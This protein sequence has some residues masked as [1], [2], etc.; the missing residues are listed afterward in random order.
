M[1][2]D[3]RLKLN[4]LIKEGNVQDNTSNIQRIKHSKKI[5]NDVNKVK[6]IMTQS[7]SLEYDLLDKACS[8]H[9]TFIIENYK[10]I[11]TRLLKGQ[12]DFIILYKFL[13]CLQSIEDGTRDQHEASYE[14][15]I[16][17]KSLYIDPKIYQETDKRNGVKIDWNEYKKNMIL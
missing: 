6:L 16:L 17:L 8:P 7:E 13:D 10:N 14:I 3:Q 1:N 2:S 12:I 4:E 15:G 5:L 9:C 11:Y